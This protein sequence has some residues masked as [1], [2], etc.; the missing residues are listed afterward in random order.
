M[1]AGTFLHGE[2]PLRSAD[3]SF[4]LAGTRFERPLEAVNLYIAGRAP[5]V[6]LSDQMPKPGFSVLAELGITLPTDLS[7]TVGVLEQLGI[8]R[9]DILTTRRHDNTAQEA[10]TLRALALRYGWQSVIVVSSKFHLRRAGFALHR[11]LKGTG[12]ELVVHGTRYEPAD[13]ARWWAT[14][15]DWRWMLSEIPKLAACLAGLGA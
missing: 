2:V 6:V 14:R 13:P 1:R 4:I 8:D 10:E 11:E 12:V 7:V 9:S 3:A 15:R 5:V